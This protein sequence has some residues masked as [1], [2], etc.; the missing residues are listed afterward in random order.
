MRRASDTC[1]VSTPT[2]WIQGDS[3]VLVDRRTRAMMSVRDRDNPLPRGIPWWCFSKL[4]VE[5]EQPALREVVARTIFF[6]VLI[7]D[8]LGLV[9]LNRIEGKRI[10]N[11]PFAR[12]HDSTGMTVP[13]T[14]L[15]KALPK[16]G[17]P[18]AIVPMVLRTV[19]PIPP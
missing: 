2:K 8:D 1:W 16:V 12:K 18:E 6:A 4:P 13:L 14:D 9:R 11:D 19:F 7:D 10:L 3:V 15:S 17:I 5:Q